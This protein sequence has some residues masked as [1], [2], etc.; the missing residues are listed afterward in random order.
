M[1][2]RTRV[3][4][5]RDKKKKSSLFFEKPQHALEIPTGPSNEEVEKALSPSEEEIIQMLL[6]DVR[7]IREGSKR[8]NQKEAKGCQCL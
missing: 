5:K 2:E 1:S 8:I 3:S 4:K 6:Q 7:D